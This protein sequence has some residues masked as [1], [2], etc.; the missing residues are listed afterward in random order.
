MQPDIT[1]QQSLTTV[2][3]GR[4]KAPAIGLMGVGLLSS[5]VSGW[6][7]IYFLRARADPQTKVGVAAFSRNAPAFFIVFV[8][9]ATVGIVIGFLVILGGIQMFRVRDYGLALT[10]SVLSLPAAL[11]TFWLLIPIGVW[12]LVVLVQPPVR[13]EFSRRAT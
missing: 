10:A 5:L 6:S 1:A 4:I 9:A 12:A 13:N 11:F 2:S 8:I 7:L 3:R